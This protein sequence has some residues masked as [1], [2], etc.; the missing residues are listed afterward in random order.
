MEF[1]KSK[2]QCRVQKPIRARCLC[3]KYLSFQRDDSSGFT[4]PRGFLRLFTG[5][6]KG[7]GVT[8][9]G[10]VEPFSRHFLVA[11]EAPNRLV[12]AHGLLRSLLAPRAGGDPL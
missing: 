10:E 8:V 1:C 3:Q 9:T 6:M 4:A 7:A 12:R 11:R 5:K 2:R